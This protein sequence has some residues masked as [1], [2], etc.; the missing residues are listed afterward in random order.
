L[1]DH[2][3]MPKRGTHEIKEDVRILHEILKRA[4]GKSGVDLEISLREL[5]SEMGEKEERKSQK[6]KK[7]I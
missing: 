3:K 7:K 1:L 6:K 5:H 2:F 4:S